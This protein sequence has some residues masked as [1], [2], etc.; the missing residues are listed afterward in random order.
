MLSSLF[1]RAPEPNSAFRRFRGRLALFKGDQRVETYWR[2][3]WKTPGK[4]EQLLDGVAGGA[5]GEYEAPFL[6]HLK[7]GGRVLEAGCGPAQIVRA[8]HQRGF[9]AEGVDYDKD[10]VAWVRQNVPEV[11]ITQGDV[12][13]LDLPD[14]ALDGY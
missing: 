13:A 2:D 7:P 14:G 3:Y 11:K 9:A 8:L 12:F 4:N 6:K 10:V 1:L 5:L